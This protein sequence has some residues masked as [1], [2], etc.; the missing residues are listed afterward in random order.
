MPLSFRCES[1][2]FMPQKC[3]YLVIIQLIRMET[4][5]AIEFK[6][7][8]EC[9]KRRI[10]IYALSAEIGLTEAG[11]YKMLSVGSI[12]VRTLE[13]IAKVLDLPMTWFFE[14][15]L[16]VQHHDAGS[17]DS[18]QLMENQIAGRKNG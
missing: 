8:A 6:I 12:K 14:K 18:G 5:K 13:K 10:R 17:A 11:F 9:R 7:R 15:E 16:P 1:K 4:T 2:L 3:R